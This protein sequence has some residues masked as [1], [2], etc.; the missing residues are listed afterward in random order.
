MT[1]HQSK[2]GDI[3]GE[4]FCLKWNDFEANVS[5]AFNDIRHE[6][7]FLDV[8]LACGDE[9]IMAHKVCTV[10]IQVVKKNSVI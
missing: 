6:R 7:D 9:Q 3:P 2:M 10:H 4:K 5:H 1:F 8:T